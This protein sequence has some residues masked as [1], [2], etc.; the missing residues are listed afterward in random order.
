MCFGLLD[1]KP[2][3]MFTDFFSS[4]FVKGENIFYVEG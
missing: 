4:P 3:G 2:E 1:A